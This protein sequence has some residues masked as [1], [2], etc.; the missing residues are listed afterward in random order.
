MM[1]RLR[2]PAAKLLFYASELFKNKE[3]TEAEKIKFKEL[4]ILKNEFIYNCLDE[5]YKDKNENQFKSEII[6]FL[7]TELIK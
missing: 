5:Y 4:I 2:L 7:K 6:E 1:D 3:I